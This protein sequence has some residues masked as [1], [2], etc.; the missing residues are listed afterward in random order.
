[1]SLLMEGETSPVQFNA[2]AAFQ[3]IPIPQSDFK[4]DRFQK[5]E[6]NI[7]QMKDVKGPGHYPHQDIDASKGNKLVEEAMAKLAV[8]QA[9]S[10]QQS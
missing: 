10:S 5:A 3:A 2:G 8:S 7:T 9:L 4:D 6:L 1:M